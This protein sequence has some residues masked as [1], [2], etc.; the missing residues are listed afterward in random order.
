MVFSLQPPFL[1]VHIDKA[2]GSSIAVALQ[3]IE[4][5]RKKSLWRRRLTWLGGFNRLGLYRSLEFSAH[6]HARE[7]QRC[8]PPEVYDSLFKFA[9]VR[10]PWDRLVSRYAYLLKTEDHPRHKFVQR[11]KGFDDYVA[12]E[13]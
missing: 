9:F 8:L 12:W 5:R 10:N 13:I 7:A 3:P 2:A 1:F 4:A 11:M 6:A